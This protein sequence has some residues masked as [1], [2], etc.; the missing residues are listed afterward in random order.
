[1]AAFMMRDGRAYTSHNSAFRHADP[2][3]LDSDSDTDW[4]AS[5]GVGSAYGL[6][7]RSPLS[8]THVASGSENRATAAHRAEAD[9]DP[10]E[11]DPS[12][13]S[14]GARRSSSRRRGVEPQSGGHTAAGFRG[15]SATLYGSRTWEPVA[16][17]PRDDPQD[18]ASAGQAS[19]LAPRRTQV[20]RSVMQGHSS[21]ASRRRRRVSHAGPIVAKPAHLRAAVSAL[22][23]QQVAETS[24][25]QTASAGMLGGRA[26][27]VGADGRVLLDTPD[28]SPE[29]SESET[30]RLRRSGGG[31]LSDSSSSESEAAPLRGKAAPNNEVPL[32]SQELREARIEAAM[33][34]ATSLNAA[35]TPAASAGGGSP[36]AWRSVAIEE[37]V[38]AATQPGKPADAARILAQPGRPT[39]LIDHRPRPEPRRTFRRARAEAAAAAVSAAAAASKPARNS[40]SASRRISVGSHT[41]SSPPSAWVAESRSVATVRPGGARPF[42]RRAASQ[43]SDAAA[44]ARTG[45]RLAAL[46][47]ELSGSDSSSSD[48]EGPRETTAS[49]SVPR[50][51]STG[52]NGSQTAQ[53]GALAR[54][55]RRQSAPGRA[56]LPAAPPASHRPPDSALSVAPS[57]SL[58]TAPLGIAARLGETAD[59]SLW[60]PASSGIPL[61]RSLFAGSLAAGSVASAS[62]AKESRSP[63]QAALGA[64][65]QAPSASRR[66]RL[67]QSKLGND[68]G[69]RGPLEDSASATWALREVD[70]EDDTESAAADPTPLRQASRGHGESARR[71]ACYDDRSAAGSHFAAMSPPMESVREAAAAAAAAAGHEGFAGSLAEKSL[72]TLRRA[73]GGDTIAPRSPTPS[74]RDEAPK[75]WPPPSGLPS[76]PTSDG[77]GDATHASAAEG[78]ASQSDDRNMSLVEGVRLSGAAARLWGLETRRLKAA[79][80]RQAAA[81]QWASEE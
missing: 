68:W 30:H 27:V 19:S 55:R 67:R 2:V 40:G 70:N 11:A 10:D 24:R 21:A 58:T 37:A 71:Q 50:R 43:T 7:L 54:M 46:V 25:T 62:T 59:P 63:L 6:G 72:S 28:A 4:V 60:T 79:A 17:P 34:V 74:P 22:E 3:V 33:R 16:R 51:I 65:G 44:V 81:M 20:D 69:G 45:R 32:R 42:G 39:H 48:D 8:R 12:P 31:L 56:G 15:V 26:Y 36:A 52:R 29:P 53:Q 1:M 61:R 23:R 75:L 77:D 38:Q 78:C 14:P 49:A 18:P 64:L 41:R 5:D 9:R 57:V 73:A 80:K 47:G 13:S 35:R 66:L 76:G